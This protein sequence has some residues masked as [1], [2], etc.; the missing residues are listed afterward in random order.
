KRSLCNGCFASR[1]HRRLGHQVVCMDPAEQHHSVKDAVEREFGCLGGAGFAG[2]NLC[3]GGLCY[4]SRDGEEYG[5]PL[6]WFVTH[7]LALCRVPPFDTRERPHTARQP[8]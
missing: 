1:A 2:S 5:F 4:F 8:I 7:A 3:D 6:L